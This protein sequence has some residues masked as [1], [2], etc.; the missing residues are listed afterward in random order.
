MPF[1]RD[2]WA[3]HG[4][5]RRAKVGI[6]CLM[7]IGGCGDS[8]ID[9][10]SDQGN[11]AGAYTAPPETALVLMPE[12]SEPQT[13]S[14]QTASPQ[15][16]SPQASEQPETP[17]AALTQPV[18]TQSYAAEQ[19][20]QAAAVGG[21]AG[22]RIAARMDQEAEAITS[23]LEGA[24][25]ERVAEGIKV[26]LMMGVLFDEGS[27]ELAPSAMDYLSRAAEHLVDL[28]DA[29]VLVVAHADGSGS[30]E[31]NL[32][33]SE[34]RAR[35]ALDYLVSAGVDRSRVDAMGRG[36]L[37]PLIID[38]RD[39]EAA[40]RENR[41]IELAIYAGPGMKASAQGGAQ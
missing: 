23:S 6:A 39:S 41:R 12:P 33:L 30:P 22:T 38:D 40:Q 4:G 20:L 25:V 9:R 2:T 13:A 14:P 15:A 16:A 28:S 37:E 27:S 29:D 10:S 34:A 3:S 35:A 31:A 11:P 32:A 8:V 21:E 36:G 18:D 7:I 1:A 26:T 24:R 19:A 5:A 17:A